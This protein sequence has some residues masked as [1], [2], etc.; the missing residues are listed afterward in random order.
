MSLKFSIPVFN[1]VVNIRWYGEE[2]NT[3][4]QFLMFLLFHVFNAFWKFLRLGNLTFFLW[5]GGGLIFVPGI[6]GGF[7]GSPRDFSGF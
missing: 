6:F 4:V 3:I 2:T 7:V 5:G 1:W